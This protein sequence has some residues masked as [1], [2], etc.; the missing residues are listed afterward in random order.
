LIGGRGSILKTA[1]GTLIYGVIL[2][3]LNIVGVNPF[4]QK[5]AIGALIVGAVAFDFMMRGRKETR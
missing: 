4:A 3:G 1:L 2:N 5:F